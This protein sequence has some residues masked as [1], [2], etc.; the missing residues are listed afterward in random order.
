[1]QTVHATTLQFRLADRGGPYIS[2]CGPGR[3]IHYRS[4]ILR[5]AL[6]APEIVGSIIEG[7]TSGVV[8]LEML[9]RPLPASW[10]EQRPRVGIGGSYD[11]G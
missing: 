5:L 3:A 1:M 6:L 10:E 7:R 8:M 9:E 2:P 11:R 4:R